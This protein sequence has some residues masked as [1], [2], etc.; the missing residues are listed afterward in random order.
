MSAW[1]VTMPKLSD[2]MEE[3]GIYEW[4]FQ[5]GEYVE[6]GAN[7]LEIE[8]DKATMEYGSPESGYLRKIMTPKGSQVSLLAPIAVL[9][10]TEDEEFDLEAVLSSVDSPPSSQADEPS[11]QPK[12][13]SSSASSLEPS[14]D[15]R[16]KASPLAK[17]IAAD[18]QLD[19]RSI[20]G[21]GPLGRIVK[22]D[23]EQA[24]QSFVPSSSSFEDRR[25]E[26]SMMRKS[27]AQSLSA[28][29]QQVPHFYLRST[30]NLDSLVRMRSQWNEHLKIQAERQGGLADKISLNDCMIMCVSRALKDHPQIRS[31]WM[32]DHILEKANIH[33]SMAVA[34]ADGLVT[35]TIHH[36]DQLGL[37][38]LSKRTRQLIAASHGGAKER[39]TLDFTSGVFT[40]SNLGTS[41]VDEFN[42]IINPPQSAILA[43]GRMR[44][45][46][47]HQMPPR[48]EI[49]VTLSC[50]HRVIDGKVGAQFLD[51]L[52]QY[53]EHPDFCML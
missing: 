7:L 51:T 17:K 2:T 53:V 6:E 47:S 31:F 21:S 42:A 19:L 35:P 36:A 43:I 22:T 29:W 28:S 13:P 37:V 30:W 4:L 11:P 16:I 44:T 32:D 48:T 15:S 14:S 33:I 8:T 26:L 46:S 12:P 25:V 45:I 24:L 20:I 23:V 52:A 5:E 39:S 3:G 34:I 9:T 1:V 40:I 27:I 10:D 49:T 18:H 50:D 38:E 41:R